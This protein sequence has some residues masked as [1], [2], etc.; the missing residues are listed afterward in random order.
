MPAT[1]SA[2]RD[3]ST[4]WPRAAA[5]LVEDKANGPAVIQE[6]SHEVAGLIAVT[7]QGGKIARAHGVSPMIESGNV[8]LPHPAIQPWVEGFIEE[9]KAFPNG[10]ND[11]QVDAMTQALNR[12]RQ[13]TS[14]FRIPESEFVIDP[15]SIPEEWPRAF[16][17]AIQ[18]N[19]VSALWGAQD[20]GGMIYLYAEHQLPHA[21]PSENTRALKKCGEW[22]PGILSRVSVGGTQSLR[23]GIA[24]LYRQHG[25]T[26]HTVQDGEDAAAYQFWQCLATRQIKAFSSLSNFLVEYRLGNDEGLLLQCSESLISGCRYMRTKPKLRVPE[27]RLLGP[28]S[29]HAWMAG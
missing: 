22:I 6:L 17:L 4:R 3:L 14:I 8:Y 23:S 5:K 29:A 12:L 21:E 15:C 13:S 2:V 20:P 25:L 27:Y 16:G 7:P 1:K 26:I 28:R 10:R 11:D 19:S 18:P 24:D 9:A